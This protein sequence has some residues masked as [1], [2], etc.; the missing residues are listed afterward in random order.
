MVLWDLMILQFYY[1]T[2]HQ[3][4]LTGMHLYAGFVGLHGEM[5]GY[6]LAVA[7]FLVAINSLVAQVR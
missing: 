1:A 5:V 6:K 2:G 7:G 3:P 4:T